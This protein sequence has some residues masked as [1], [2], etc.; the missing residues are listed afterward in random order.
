MMP[1]SDANTRNDSTQWIDRN[2]THPV[3]V[4]GRNNWAE[5]SMTFDE[6][7]VP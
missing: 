6:A 1:V 4:G 2:P 3:Q 5:T 7:L